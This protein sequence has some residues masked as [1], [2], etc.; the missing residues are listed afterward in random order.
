VRDI[1]RSIS[2]SAK[3]FSALAVP[4]ENPDKK[5]EDHSA[6]AELLLKSIF[7]RHAGCLEVWDRIKEHKKGDNF[8]VH[9]ITL[10]SFTSNHMLKFTYGEQKIAFVS[11]KTH[12]AKVTNRF[13]DELP[14]QVQRCRVD[15][16][17]ERSTV[18]PKKSW[19]STTT[20]TLQDPGFL[21]LFAPGRQPSRTLSFIS[22]KSKQRSGTLQT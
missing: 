21:T 22:V 1:H 15:A 4:R 13:K 5:M 10:I 6:T 14:D 9:G 8:V 12:F 2:D 18:S 16:D 7:A 20:S 3:K 19:T 17:T 11:L